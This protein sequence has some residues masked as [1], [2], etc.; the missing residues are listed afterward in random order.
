MDVVTIGDVSIPNQ[1]VELAEKLSPSF[2]QSGGS[3]G[4]LG[5]AWPVLNTVK[6]IQQATPVQNMITM[7]LVSLPVFTV[8]LDRGDDNGFYTF[9][10]IDA[11]KANVSEFDIK[12]TAI[13]SSQGFW[14]F[15]STQA[16]VNGKT[17]TLSGNTAIADTGTTLAL[18]SDSIVS[19]IYSAIPGSRMDNSQGGFV[20]PK[21]ATVPDV[22]FAV[23]DHMF[24]IN[25]TDFAYGL[26]DDNGMLFG[27]IQSRGSNP[28][29]ILGD[30]FLKSVYVVFD[31]GNTRIG[32]AQRST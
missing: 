5:L 19:E 10:V 4:L 9:G 16:I 17:I 13:D 30:I 21:D 12:Y 27:G 8:N 25:A 26:P 32:V 6:P 18:V 22:A 28:F 24:T 11:A 15:S 20:F 3:D 1:A 7:G 31:Q 2:Q 14:R 29:D 23:G